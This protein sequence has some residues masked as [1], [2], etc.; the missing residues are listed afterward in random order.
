MKHISESLSYFFY[1]NASV[2][3]S[4]VLTIIYVMLFVS[5][6][7]LIRAIHVKASRSNVT[8]LAKDSAREKLTFSYFK[9]QKEEE[10]KWMRDGMQEKVPW[11]YRMDR[12]IDYS[13]LRNYM[14]FMTADILI[15]VY[16]ALIIISFFV[17]YFAGLGVLMGLLIGIGACVVVRSIL[18]F[19]ADR[20][21]ELIENNMVSFVNAVG[22]ESKSSDD[23]IT[24][25]DS[26]K[27]TLCRPLRMVITRCCSE[28]RSLGQ[29]DIAMYH[30][31]LA[32]ENQQLKKIIRNLE[33]CAHTDADYKTVIDQCR[34]GLKEHISA[35]EERKAILDNNRASIVV[36]LCL[37]LLSLF[38]VGQIVET[39]N[40]F[41]YLWSFLLGKI[42]LVYILTVMFICFVSLFLAKERD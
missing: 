10:A 32:V 36:M 42:V 12:L 13:G 33:M 6:F 27:K 38:L 28:A 22:V 9:R 41:S 25:L 24:I 4:I 23:L 14:P 29:I 8:S 39:S 7:C 1:G 2:G 40:V 35:R 21:F 15:V 30:F 5:L 37:G 26:A 31:E 16:V 18:R 3:Q 19:V 17:C 20:N 34:L 11:L